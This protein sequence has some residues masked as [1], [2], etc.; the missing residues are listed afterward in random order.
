MMGR[1]SHRFP[2]GRGGMPRY[3]AV[4]ALSLALALLAAGACERSATDRTPG[5]KDS[6]P[7]VETAE[8]VSDGAAAERPVIVALGDSLTEGYGVTRP[9]SWPAL[10][11][12]RLEAEGYPHRVVN[13]GIAGDT[14]AGGLARMDWLL[15]QRIDI[16]IV[17]LGG[18]DGLRGVDPAA[19]RANLSAIVRKG[20][21]ARATVVFVGMTM[22]FNYGSDYKERYDAVFPELAERYDVPFI[23]FF[24]KDVAGV[25]K[26]TLPDGIH[27]NGEGYKVILET[28]WET[29]E[30]LLEN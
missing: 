29:L 8:S 25:R 27:P 11:Q 7:P 14:T 30:P 23:P 19:T 3:A 21:D 4:P 16:L 18:N 28:V 1:R 10:L 20:L 2:A 12:S 24:L 22:P 15:R 9:E 5:R 26:L 6:A 17:E 13:A